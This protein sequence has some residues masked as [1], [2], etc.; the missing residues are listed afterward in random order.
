[1]AQLKAAEQPQVQALVKA[2]TVSATG[3]T[4]NISLTLPSTQFQELL[5]PKA[6]A[7]HHAARRNSPRPRGSGSVAPP[8]SSPPLAAGERRHIHYGTRPKI[9]SRH[10]QSVPFRE[11]QP[12]RHWCRCN[13]H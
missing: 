13:W 3:A 11:K 10:L 2:L 6:G 12:E 8:G 1:M 5:Q 4:I 7:H 9:E